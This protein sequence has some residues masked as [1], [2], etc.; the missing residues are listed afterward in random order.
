M[1]KIRQKH[2][3]PNGIQIDNKEFGN[4]SECCNSCT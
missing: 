1:T 4:P 3:L 2:N